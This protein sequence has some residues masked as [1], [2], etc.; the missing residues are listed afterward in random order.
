[1]EKLKNV[2]QEEQQI[3]TKYMLSDAISKNVKVF[4][5]KWLQSLQKIDNICK[6]RNRY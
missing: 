4:V 1:M 2:I 3:A 5:K 6:E